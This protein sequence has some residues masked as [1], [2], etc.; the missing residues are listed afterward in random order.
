[1]LTQFVSCI[2]QGANMVV[3]HTLRFPVRSGL[4]V[5]GTAASGAL[6]IMSLSTDDATEF[7]IDVTFFQSNRQDITV[8][9]SDIRPINVA[10]S[11][12]KMPGVLKVEAYRDLS[13]V[14]RNGPR[15]KRMSL[16]GL[17][18]GR[19]LQKLLDRDL[20]PIALPDA[21][22]AVSEKLA[23][24]LDVHRGEV[25]SVEVTEGR[26]RQVELPI[27]A[28]LQGY[29]GLQ[30][31][32]TLDQLNRIAG[33]GRVVTAADLMVDTKALPTL[34]RELKDMPAVAAVMLLRHSLKSF[35][36][37]LGQNIDIMMSVFITLAVIIT[38]GVVYNSAR[39]QLSERGRELAS[40]RVLGFTRA[41]VARI[42]LGEVVLLTALAIPLSW[43]LGYVFT[44]VLISGFDT[45]LYRVPFIIDR[46]TYVFS[47]LIMCAAA[48]VSALIVGIRVSRLDLIKVLK[49]RE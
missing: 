33:D 6:L 45:E 31:F 2:S 32:V 36:K 47:S 37:T 9:F 23:D 4:T 30:A 24:I 39:I 20:H 26:R 7:M 25:I 43:V 1:M 28:I 27:T 29:I 12:R 42:L 19:D 16:Q 10:D 38:F 8:A 48:A 22:V 35:R 3:R 14:L 44:W 21:G 11:L 13:V 18:P 46:N 5:L 41:E 40:L 34:Y 49:T 17:P 15:S